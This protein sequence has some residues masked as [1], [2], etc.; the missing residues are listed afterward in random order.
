M[1]LMKNLAKSRGYFSSS[2]RTALGA[3]SQT[4]T[5]QRNYFSFVEKMRDKFHKPWRHF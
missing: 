5:S 2:T 3:I 4:Q 1:M